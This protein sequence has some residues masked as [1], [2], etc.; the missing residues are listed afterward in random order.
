MLDIYSM[1]KSFKRALWLLV[2]FTFHSFIFHSLVACDD[3]D[4]FTTDRSSVLT[5]SSDS[6]VFDTLI[7]T[8]P[9]S[10]KTLIVYNRGDKGV[11]I[12]E[13]RLN[14]G[15]ASPFRINVDGQDISRTADNRAT[16]FE[17]RRRDSIIVRIEVTVPEQVNDDI[18]KID[19]ALTFTLENGTLQHVSLIVSGRN[20]FFL[21]GTTLTADTTFTSRRPIVIYD[22]LVVAP[23]VTLTLEA[24]TQLLFHDKAG[25]TVHG[26]LVAKGTLEAPVILR[27]DR[28]DHM[29]DYLPYDRMPNRWEGLV[30]T[31][32]SHDNR[33]DYLDLH[34]GS[35][36]IRCDSAGTDMLKLQLVNSLIHNVGEHG[37]ELRHCRSEVFNTE[38]SN[39]QGHCAYIVGGDAQF[40]HCTLARF[41]AFAYYGGQAVNITNQDSIGFFALDRADFINCV[42]TG[43]ADDAVLIP[44]LNREEMP[45][46]VADLPINYHFIHCFLTTEVPEDEL[47]ADRFVNC[48]TDSLEAD[49]NREKHFQVID[50]HNF[51]YDFTPVEASP[52][53]GVAL[54]T[55]SALY[56]LDRYGRSRTAD[57]APDAGCYEFV[58]TDEKK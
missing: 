56:P 14:G 49:I 32:E 30:F 57:G 28:T 53:R 55:Y 15:H 58:A 31:S 39:A 29:F 13:V 4:T 34:S 19:D 42:V 25:L 46:A 16:D 20:G 38:I 40:I 51:L 54:P 45:S 37:L 9:S 33:L 27:G 36:G 21:K 8:V 43:Y 23:D 47:Y 1:H 18:T 5:F 26:T 2:F 24:G 3:Y 10:T 22:S 41:G 11:R 6:I 7:A 50:G 35:Y 52:I 12:N 17:V 48:R 44:S